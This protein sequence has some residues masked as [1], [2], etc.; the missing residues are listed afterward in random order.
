MDREYRSKECAAIL[1]KLHKQNN[2]GFFLRFKINIL[3]PNEISFNHFDNKFFL[4]SPKKKE[5]K[6]CLYAS[7][8]KRKKSKPF[9]YTIAVHCC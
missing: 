4:N 8:L 9:T 2:F 7:T 3:C 1:K 6:P 5:A